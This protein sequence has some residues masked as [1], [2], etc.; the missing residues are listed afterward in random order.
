MPFTSGNDSN[1]LQGTDEVVEGAGAGDDTYII[2]G[3]IGATQ[4]ISISDAEGTNILWLP[5]NL[6]VASSIFAADAAQLTLS[7]SA[8]I[9]I[10]GASTFTYRLGGDPLSGTGGV[11]HDYATFVTTDMG[12]ATLP[13]GTATEAGG[14][15]TGV[16]ADGSTT[17]GSTSGTSEFSITAT[18]AVAEGNTGTATLDVTVTRTGDTTAAAT[19]DVSTADGTATTADSD[20]TA[21]TAQ[22]VSFAAGE[23]TKTVTLSITGDTTV[24]VDETFT[25]SLAN[26]TGGAT[27]STTA[28]TATLTITNDDAATFVLTTASDDNVVG[29]AADDEITGVVSGLSSTNTL[30]TTDKVDGGAGDDML[31]VT[32]SSDFA[33]FSTGFMKNIETLEITNAAT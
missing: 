1:I 8:V 2:G 3:G 23:T 26:A 15:D 14:A 33:G 5:T 28:G 30:Q 31:K 19:V 6:T 17:N 13:T 7:N 22:T 11:T 4:T 24:E 29:V 9:N 25:A 18:A 12:A 21:V 27:I 16:N 32:M 20:Y 10:N